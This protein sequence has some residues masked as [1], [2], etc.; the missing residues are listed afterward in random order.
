MTGIRTLIVA[1][2]V[3]AGGS[4]WAAIPS[5]IVR[6][7]NN[8]LELGDTEAVIEA[9]EALIEAALDS[10]DDAHAIDSAFEA[11]T[12][13]C[14]RGFCSRAAAAAPLMANANTE[15]V[16]PALA[17]L[18][19][20]YAGWSQTKDRS[21]DA[22]MMSALE[23]VS[24]EG[25]TLLTISAFDSYHLYVVEKGDLRTILKVAEL[26]AAHYKPVWHLIPVNWASME[27]SATATLFARDRST[28]AI[29]RLAKL[30]VALYPYHLAKRKEYP[31]ID[32]LYY[33]TM[34]WR[35]AVGAFFRSRGARMAAA[36]KEADEYVDVE[37]RKITEQYSADRPPT[38]PFCSG[39]FRKGPQPNYPSSASDRGYVG[40]VIV[41]FDINE[42][43][44]EN[45][46][47][48]AA[49]PDKKF[50]RAVLDS[51]KPMKWYFDEEQKNPD[52]RRSRSSRPGII[53]F[54][55][56]ISRP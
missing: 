12:Q 56:V 54:E 15:E 23:A 7:F 10:P 45:V 38:K 14:L 53:P 47:I 29:D 22:S 4:A 48:L 36:L 27:L 32:G 11:G 16:T 6:S 40:A 44:L 33:Q 50:E 35:N 2:M 51:M 19:I 8:A 30:E 34:A 31:E 1:V 49:V 41:G 9:S 42:G 3:A 46:R 43:E 39:G 55:F 24:S 37:T 21:T 5:D 20:T 17:N 26:G 52:C 13:L 18:L 25:P 28:A